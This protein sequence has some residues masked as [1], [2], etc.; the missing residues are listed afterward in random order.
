M[1]SG[2]KLQY[3]RRLKGLTQEYIAE[4]VGV[5]ER[6]ISKVECENSSISQET[7]DKWVKALNGGI[8]LVKKEKVDK[9]TK[10]Y[11]ANHKKDGNV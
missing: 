5:S 4:C 6:W 2:T 9:R 10:E 7:H 3:L 11:K 8:T 1:L